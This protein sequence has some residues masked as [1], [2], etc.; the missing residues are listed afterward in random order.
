MDYSERKLRT[1]EEYKG[2]IIDLRVDE[3]ELP[4][5]NRGVRE[6][7]DHPGGVAVI[8]IDE[9]GFVYCVRQYRYAFGKHMLEVPAG[10]LERGEDPAACAVRELSEETGL[11][12]GQ[13]TYLGQL[14]PSPGF[15]K[16]VLH[17]YLGRELS[18]GQNHP[19]DDEFLDVEKIHLV[20]LAD[21]VVRGEI[22][23]AK[24]I[25]AVLK[26][27]RVLEE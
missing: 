7:V 9:A 2:R 25:V 17:I 20:E 26:A 10:K 6:I 13:I 14:Y 1:L 21:R 8:P 11:R 4:N 12:A 22:S 24:T 19:D 5:G 3:V 16:E 27:K 15:C 23:D 18:F